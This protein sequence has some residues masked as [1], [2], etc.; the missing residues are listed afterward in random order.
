MLP[1]LTS[2]AGDNKVVSSP[3]SNRISRSGLT[4]VVVVVVASRRA[5]CQQ[6]RHFHFIGSWKRV[7]RGNGARFGCVT[8]ES[9]LGDVRALG[10]RAPRDIVCMRG[11]TERRC[12]L[13][14]RREHVGNTAA[15][16]REY[17]TSGRVDARDVTQVGRTS[18]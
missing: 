18:D 9:E 6:S 11:L 4:L 12:P 16:S 17:F 13:W 1:L 5:A 7:S 14:I 3:P 2:T 10:T 8:L 15:Q